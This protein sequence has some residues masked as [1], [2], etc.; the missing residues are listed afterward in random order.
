MPESFCNLS[1]FCR[2]QAGEM[3]RDRWGATTPASFS[4]C[5][6][7]QSLG[8][9]PGLWGGWAEPG[10]Y[11][12]GGTDLP[13]FGCAKCQVCLSPFH[14]ISWVCGLGRGLPRKPDFRPPPQ[15]SLL[16]R[17]DEDRQLSGSGVLSVPGSGLAAAVTP[18]RQC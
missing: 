1:G 16:L 13:A 6:L 10:W 4:S 18:T 12:C 9:T 2:S 14:S 17:W 3:N 7:D 8:H 11:Q 5:Q 15:A